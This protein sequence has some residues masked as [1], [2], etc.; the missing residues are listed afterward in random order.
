MT[1]TERISRF[2]AENA[3]MSE[4]ERNAR[5]VGEWLRSKSRKRM[6]DGQR[7]YENRCDILG[8]KRWIIGENGQPQ[9]DETLVNSRIAHGLVRKLTDQKCQYLFGRPF[10]V[11]A[12]NDGFR[13]ALEEFFDREMRNR[14][15]NLCKEAVNKGI[16]WLQVYPDGERLGCRKIPS[17]QVIPLWSNGEHTKLDGVIRIFSQERFKGLRKE[18]VLCAEEWSTEGVRCWLYRNGELTADPERREK[19]HFRMDGKPYNFSEVPFIPFK[20]NEEELPLLQFI[21]PL[22]D[23]YDL[24]KSEDANTLLDSPN[25]ILVLQ[26]YD[27]EDLGEFRRNLAQ[28]KAVKVTDNGGL[29]IK[30]APV[31]TDAV[32]AHLERTRK[33]LYEAGR[34][35]DTQRQSL[36][37][38]SGVALKF[39]YA[40]LDLDCSGIETEFAAGFEKLFRFLKVCDDSCK[41]GRGERAGAAGSQR[42]GE[43]LLR[44]LHGGAVRLV[45]AG[46]GRRGSFLRTGTFRVPGIREG[47]GGCRREQPG[48]QL[49][50]REGQR[51]KP[52][53]A[54][55]VYGAEGGYPLGHCE[56]VFRGRRAIPG[57][58]GR[59]RDPESEFDLSGAEATDPVRAKRV[60]LPGGVANS[61]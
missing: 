9:A 51:E 20:Y 40:D 15:K 38:L 35:V 26:N 39:L 4:E 7:Y 33:D 60:A 5:A 47:C 58:C 17:E 41:N 27:G 16:A 22:I 48:G 52:A 45:D 55:G 19:S 23:D 57:N 25:S 59:K 43:A 44:A 6:L 42:W 14:V 31:E 54:G 28:Y 10:T 46:R 24:L 2:L 49:R 3:A 12:E 34:G 29:D 30:S 36:G 32:N 1:E 56:A 11:R 61:G 53:G 18:T 21:K 13:A 50:K 37:N 8:R